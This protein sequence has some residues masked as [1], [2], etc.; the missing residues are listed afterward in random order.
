MTRKLPIALTLL[1]L[2]APTGAVAYQINEK[3]SSDG[4]VVTYYNAAPEHDWAVERGVRAW[5]RSGADVEFTEAPRDEAELIL[6]AETQGLKGHARS[7]H[8]GDGVQRPGDARIS[9][10]VASGDAREQRFSIALIAAHELGHVLGLDHE[11]SG[12]ATMNATITAAAPIRCDQPPAKQW[13]C[14][15]LEE[16]DIRGAV[17]LYGGRVDPPRPRYCPKV[18]PKPKPKP[19]PPL[20]PEPLT[21]AESVALTPADAI[22]VT[23]DPGSSTRVLVRWRN[24]ESERIRSVVVARSRASCPSEPGDLERKTVNA[25]PGQEGTV[26]FP[27]ELESVCYAVWS[28]DRKGTL[29]RRPA[30]AWLDGPASPDPPRGFEATL[31]RSHPLGDNAVSLHWQNTTVSTLSEVVIARAKGR[32]PTRPPRRPRSWDA[33][34]AAP[35]A[36]QRHRDLRFYPGAD[37]EGHCYAVWSR[38]RFGR[39]SR[40]ATAWPKVAAPEE[41][42][43]VLAG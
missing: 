7:T 34:A 36:F 31:A 20:A 14:G 2:A 32:C 25:V 33:P 28:R 18:R 15:L 10:P 3:V 8:R 5:N 38:D 40:P 22:E 26:T 41:E 13:R 12:C 21:P 17:E 43:I 23:S 16:D 30:T 27:L 35:D 29:S 1:A 6:V 42:V 37:A 4:R 11:D 19:P 39:L 24:G 9:L